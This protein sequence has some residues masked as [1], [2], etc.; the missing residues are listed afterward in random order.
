MHY[1]EGGRYCTQAYVAMHGPCSQ[2]R[3][4]STCRASWY[5]VAIIHAASLT[6]PYARQDS[7][8]A[9]M[10][11]ELDLGQLWRP[12][13]RRSG[14]DHATTARWMGC[15]PPAKTGRSTSPR[16]TRCQPKT[17]RRCSRCDGAC[18]AVDQATLAR[19]LPEG[20]GCIASRSLGAQ[21]KQI[22]SN[23]SLV[24]NRTKTLRRI[25]LC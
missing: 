24:G 4:I 8:T 3:T 25:R 2:L 13:A 23:P 18:G 11:H 22:K 15:L 20:H 14:S 5:S 12:T 16:P 10:D 21:D 19:A 6:L 9:A 1:S 17:S 7:L